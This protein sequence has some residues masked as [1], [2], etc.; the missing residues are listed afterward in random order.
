MKNNWY[1]LTGGPSAGKTSLVKALEEM[2][3]TVVHEAARDYIDEQI[4]KGLTLQ[5]I[6][7]DEVQFQKITLR[8]KV[9]LEKNLDKEKTIFFDRAIPDT[10]AYYRFKGLDPDADEELQFALQNSSYKKIFFLEMLPY[11]QDYARIESPEQA[12][13]IHSL[14]RDAYTETH[15]SLVHIPVMSLEKRI[16]VLLQSL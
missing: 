4:S 6:R 9:E 1:V 3:H 13:V 14:L 15:G 5:E 12:Q 2:G 8:K 16:E 7:K 10:L 11:K